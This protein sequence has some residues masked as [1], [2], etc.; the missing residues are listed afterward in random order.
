MI[1]MGELQLLLR[2]S[3]ASKPKV[4]IDIDG[5]LASI[6][7]LMIERLNKAKGTNFTLEDCKDWG[8]KSIGSSYAEMMQIYVELWRERWKEIPFTVDI[9]LINSLADYYTVHLLTS[10]SASED[11][12]T[13]GTVDALNEW[14][15]MH[16]IGEDKIHLV[17]CPPARDKSTNFDYDV[18]IDDSPSLARSIQHN[19]RQAKLFLVDSPYNRHIEDGKGVTR[20][21]T[22]SEA[23]RMLID[24][25]RS[26]STRK[27]RKRVG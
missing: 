26:K 3:D 9:N 27:A 5:T 22:A 15:N 12:L 2:G 4:A 24:L 18:Y 25:A 1:F 21:A 6:H 10:R 7:G 23:I 14:R 8:F 17:L 19:T 11:G 16:G 13:A 20:V